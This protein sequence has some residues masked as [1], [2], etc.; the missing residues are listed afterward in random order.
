VIRR[1]RK[2]GRG[3]VSIDGVGGL[4]RI[5]HKNTN[6]GTEERKVPLRK[7]RGK[8]GK[9]KARSE[10]KVSL[11]RGATHSSGEEGGYTKSP[12]EKSSKLC[13]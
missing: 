1:R 10:K 9:K 8:F 12:P 2:I 7:K 6:R 4:G 13:S 11:E 5:T 3:L